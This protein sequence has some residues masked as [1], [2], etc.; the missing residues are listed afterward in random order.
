MLKVLQRA[1]G[2]ASTVPQAGQGLNA[3]PGLAPEEGD[4]DLPAAEKE[5]FG[6]LRLVSPKKKFYVG[7]M[8]PLE[9][10]ACFRAGADLRVDGLPRLN[11]DAFTMNKLGDQPARSQQLI[12]GVPYTVFTWQT[13]LTAVKAGDYEMTIEI[14]TTVTST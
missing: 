14:P 5:S 2:H 9:L 10:K 4:D 12:G 3:A 7:E 11:S 6:F 8:V 1:A 13:A